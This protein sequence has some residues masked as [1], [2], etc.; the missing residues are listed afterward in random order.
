[1]MWRS[2]SRISSLSVELAPGRSEKTW[3]WRRLPKKLLILSFSEFDPSWKQNS[4]VILFYSMGRYMSFEYSTSEPNT[5]KLKSD[6]TIYLITWKIWWTSRKSNF[7]GWKVL[8]CFCIDMIF[9]I[10]SESRI[11]F[12]IFI[13][14][15]I[16]IFTSCDTYKHGEIFIKM[17]ANWRLMVSLGI[18]KRVGVTLSATIV[19]KECPSDQ[20][21]YISLCT[22]WTT[23]ERMKLVG[24]YISN[25]KL[26]FCQVNDNIRGFGEAHLL[27]PHS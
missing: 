14:R 21:G 4:N 5:P 6:I 8:Y 7:F 27:L 22:T 2:S 17:F 18:D 23:S 12:S 3:N 9:N 13:T 24:R 15:M 16:C 25:T 20:T 26:Q 10:Q 1:M 19:G 11:H